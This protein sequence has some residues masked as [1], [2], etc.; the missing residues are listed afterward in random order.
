LDSITPSPNLHKGPLSLLARMPHK[1]PLLTKNYSP[2]SNQ[3]NINSNLQM[4][5]ASIYQV[6]QVYT[7][8]SLFFPEFERVHDLLCFCLLT[9]YRE[10]CIPSYHTGITACH[11]K[12]YVANQ[13]A[14]CMSRHGVEK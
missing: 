12:Y 5:T 8:L 14:E 4:K 7:P 10:V 11:K 2:S 1:L 13:M 3:Q 9:H 6:F